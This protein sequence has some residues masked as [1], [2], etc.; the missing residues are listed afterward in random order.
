MKL[1]RTNNIETVK[2][3]QSFLVY[4]FQAWCCAVDR[5]VRTK[6]KSC[7]ECWLSYL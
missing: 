3:S 4:L 6:I 7:A 5:Q 2:V 1:V